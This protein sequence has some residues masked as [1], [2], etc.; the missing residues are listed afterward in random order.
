MSTLLIKVILAI[1]EPLMIHLK[2]LNLDVKVYL[3][4]VMINHDFNV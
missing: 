3:L 2:L 1:D 4:I